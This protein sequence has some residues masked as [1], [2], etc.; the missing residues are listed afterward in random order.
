MS[1]DTIAERDFLSADQEQFASICGDRN[2]IHMDALAARRT[3]AGFTVVHGIHVLLWG[4]DSLFRHIN[5]CRPVASIKVSFEK[6]IYVGDR[7]KAVLALRDNRRLR[8]D[9]VAEGVRVVRLEVALGDPRSSNS[10]PS[11]EPL[12]KP[13]EPLSLTFE[14]MKSC[15]GRIPFYSI[16]DAVHRTFPSAVNALGVRRV[17][18]LACSSFLVGM[19]CPGLHSVYRGLTLVSTLPTGG[20]HDDLHFRVVDTDFS[21]STGKACRLRRRLDGLYRCARTTR[22][23]GS[24]GSGDY[25]GQSG[26]R[27]I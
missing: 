17:A 24:E 26:A 3:L 11:N 5:D 4:L 12:L 7:V 6:M 9:M 8:L 1:S 13:A 10:S 16:R 15:H 2:P 25:C 18:A 23:R 14:Q 19:V 21:L 22:T 20:D 27:R